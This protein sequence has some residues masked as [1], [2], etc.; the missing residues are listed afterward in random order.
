MCTPPRRQLR[1]LATGGPWR[2]VSTDGNDVAYWIPEKHELHAFSTS[3]RADMVIDTLP[4]ATMREIVW[5]SR[6]RT[7]AYLVSG[8]NPPGVRVIDMDSG[9]RRIVTGSF[10][11]IIV[12]DAEHLASVGIEG[13]QRISIADGRRE[14]V[15][16]VKYANQAAYS[17]SGALLGILASN[18]NESE[19]AADD[20]EPDCTGG[21]FALFVHTTATKR[22]V[23]VPFPKGFDS[24]LDFAFSPDDSS[25]AVTFG[26]AA[27]DYPGDVARVYVVSL[28]GLTM[29][30]ISAADRLSVKAQWSPDGR[31]IVYSDYS[32]SN[33]PLM[34]FDTTM[35]K[36]I[37]LTNP[38]DDGPDEILGWRSGTPH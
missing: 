6:G 37:R 3:D 22:P 17:R 23:K 14:L 24:V 11:S 33:S 10:S 13:V 36:T 34:A 2:T 20:D 26:A 18:I 9:K 1:T 4:G 30:P 27:C 28:P 21:T 29:K 38:G 12:P 32:G 16:Q 5:S 8:A 31:R 25:I 7:L 35:G 15:A 19:A